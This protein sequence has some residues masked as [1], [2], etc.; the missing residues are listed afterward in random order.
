MIPVHTLLMILSLR[1]GIRTEFFA[2]LLLSLLHL[3]LN[4]SH[5][6]R[7]CLSSLPAKTWRWTPPFLLLH[8]WVAI[9]LIQKNTKKVAQER[10]CSE[11]VVLSCGP[12]SPRQSQIGTESLQCPEWL[13]LTIGLLNKGENNT[14]YC[15][16]MCSYI[17]LL[18][19]QLNHFFFYLIT[20]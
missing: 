5:R 13:S 18:F 12:G 14:T 16:V 6:M 20:W 1:E 10:L 3:I 7:S 11:H 15:H 17:F 8:Q 2:F 19:Q 9:C 4:K